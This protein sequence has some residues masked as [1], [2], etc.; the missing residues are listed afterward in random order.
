LNKFSIFETDEFSKKLNK[1]TSKDSK[2]I[3]SKLKEYVYPQLK[4][5][6]AY[7]KNIKKLRGYNPETWRYRIGEFRLF[8]SIDYKEKIIFILTIDRRKDVYK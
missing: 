1:L 6:P 4:D 3:L 8:Y 2:F 5:E 7:G